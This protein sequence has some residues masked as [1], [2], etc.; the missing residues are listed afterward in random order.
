MLLHR[1]RVEKGGIGACYTDSPA[2]LP[3]LDSLVFV[4]GADVG[5]GTMVRGEGEG[6]SRCWVVEAL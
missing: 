4:E 1:P 3:L 2:C 6:E 5:R